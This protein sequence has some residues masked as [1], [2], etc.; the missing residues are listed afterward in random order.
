MKRAAA[1]RLCAAVLRLCAPAFW[2]GA[3]A[4]WISACAPSPLEKARRDFGLRVVNPPDTGNLAVTDFRHVDTARADSLGR[5]LGARGFHEELKS[6][7]SRRSARVS[8][9]PFLLPSSYL[10][11]WNDYMVYLTLRRAALDR[12]GSSRRAEAEEMAA[13]S[14]SHIL[15]SY[16]LDMPKYIDLREI[17]I[18]LANSQ[19]E[20]VRCEKVAYEAVPL[21]PRY[22]R[23]N[24]LIS[25]Y[26]L[27]GKFLFPAVSESGRPLIAP[28][29]R[30]LKVTLLPGSGAQSFLFHL[31]S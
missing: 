25:E 24:Q 20:S 8:P 29:T 19:G 27:V 11:H 10:T 9:G 13:Q 7:G 14:A 2:L 15:F 3:A 12:P 22:D 26:R 28:N 17:A 18:V 5:R 16:V 4:L 6:V 31:G 23:N 30:S 1:L 21:D